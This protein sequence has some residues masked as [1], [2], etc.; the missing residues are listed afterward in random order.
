VA[1]VVGGL[2]ANTV[3][4]VDISSTGQTRAKTTSFVRIGSSR[5]NAKGRMKLPA[6]KASRAGTFMMRMTTP[7]GK[8]Y[9][10]KVKVTAKTTTGA[11]MKSASTAGMKPG[12]STGKQG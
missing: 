3:I 11:S 9:Y 4:N 1:P 10:L 5:T 12:K 2:P 7:A 6:F 8:A